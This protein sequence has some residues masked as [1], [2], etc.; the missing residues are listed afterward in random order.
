MD[1]TRVLF[2]A[3]CPICN[4]EICHYRAYSEAKGLKLWFDDLNSDA[5]KGWDVDPDTAARYLHVFQDGQL[6]RGIPAFLVLW[7]EMPRYRWLASIVGLPG[8]RQLASVI[9]DHMLA[10]F[11]YR[12]HLKR[13]Q[14]ADPPTS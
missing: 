1:N 7:R 12:R 11:L 6:Y 4:S 10:A 9:Y 8:V 5:L 13:V 2:N 14:S 3:D